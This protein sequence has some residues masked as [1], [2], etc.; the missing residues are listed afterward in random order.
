MSPSILF[1]TLI[2]PLAVAAAGPASPSPGSPALREALAF[3]ASFDHGLNADFARGD[4]TLYSYVNAQQREQGGVAGLPD[5]PIK[6]AKNEGRF[7]D[8]L[9]FTQKNPGRP[10]FKDGGNIGYNRS[11]WN[12]TISVWLRLS[13]DLDLAPGYCDPLQVIGDNGDKGFIFIGFDKDTKP[14]DFEYGVRPLIDIWDPHRVGWLDLPHDKR[15]M[16]QVKRPPFDRGRWTHV[17]FTLEHINRKQAKPTAKL[18]LDGQL[19]GA[20]QGWDLTLGW[21]ENSALLVMGSAYV[22]F[23]DELSVFDRVLTEDEVKALYQLPNGVAD[24]YGQRDGA[25]SSQRFPSLP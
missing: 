12:R 2:A 6:I 13:P 23:L 9:L 17:V 16:L 1:A 19:Q 18:Y 8:A 11:N 20:I 15:P 5:G 22:G 24:L 14:R 4:R 25:S 21:A 3:H 7:G 10:F